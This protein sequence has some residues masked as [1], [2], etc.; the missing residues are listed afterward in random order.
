[1]IPSKGTNQFPDNTFSFWEWSAPVLQ[2][3]EEVLQKLN[4]LRLDGRVIKDII[5]V[6]MGYGWTEDNIS[7]MADH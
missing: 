7:S 4:E 5:S 2:T 1:M 6:G 3:P